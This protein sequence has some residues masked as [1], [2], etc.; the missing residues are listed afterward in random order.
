VGTF[1]LGADASSTGVL[2]VTSEFFLANRTNTAQLTSPANG[3]FIMNG[4]IANIDT[5]IVDASTSGAPTTRTTVINLLGGKLNMM[6]HSIGSAAAPITTVIFPDVGQTATIANLSGAGING[7]CLTLDN[8]GT[9]VLEGANGYTGA[10]TI[11]HGTLLLRGTIQGTTSVMIAE[12]MLQLNASDRIND[13]AML[14]LTTGT[15][16]S[17][18]FSDTLGA[19]TLAGSA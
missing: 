9:L 17:V 16:D 13:S 5:D 8:A 10:T 2:N 6:G 1:T 12:G 3:T 14:S 7:A 4:G 11:N 19:V 18:G 15:F